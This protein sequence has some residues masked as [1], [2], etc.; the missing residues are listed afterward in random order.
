MIEKLCR[1]ELITA[2]VDIKVFF[3]RDYMAS[4]LLCVGCVWVTDTKSLNPLADIW[5]CSMSAYYARI[6]NRQFFARRRLHWINELKA[7]LILENKQ[8]C[9]ESAF[10]LKSSS[11]SSFSS[12]SS[13][14]DHY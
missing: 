8:M 13:L 9:C 14:K 5:K 1:S 10:E 7:V 12:S 11:T 4:G 6:L 2:V 3:L